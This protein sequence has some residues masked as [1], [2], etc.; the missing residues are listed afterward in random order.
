MSVI[1]CSTSDPSCNASASWLSESTTFDG[2]KA[3]ITRLPTDAK[4]A[5][6]LPLCGVPRNRIPYVD[7]K[8]E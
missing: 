4:P 5:L 6:L 2:A 1:F 8:I 7:T 3:L